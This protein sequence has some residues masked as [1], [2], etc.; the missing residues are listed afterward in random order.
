MTAPSEILELP[1]IIR[2]DEVLHFIGYPPDRTPPGHTEELLASL[3][4][5]AR[6]LSRARGAFRLISSEDAPLIGLTPIAASSLAIGLVTIG[7]EIEERVGGY[8]REGEAMKALALDAAGSAA[9]EEAADRLGAVIAAG[10][11]AGT[12]TGTRTG[13][14]AGTRAGTRAGAPAAEGEAPDDGGEA[15]RRAEPVSCRV[16]PGYGQWSLA[17]QASLFRLLPHREMGVELLPSMLMVP[18]KSISFAMWLGA[19]SRPLEGLAGC[20]RCGLDACRY[21]RETRREAHGR[22]RNQRTEA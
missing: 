17:S 14:P 2:R 16:S 11:I 13:T 12:P 3:I 20:A 21:R 18:R 22:E 4:D 19:D 8:L 1:V 9:V 6:S 10:D 7:A 15:T 5:E